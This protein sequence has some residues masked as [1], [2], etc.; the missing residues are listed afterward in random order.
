MNQICS[1][2]SDE[3][4]D[5]ETSSSDSSVFLIRSVH[6]VSQ[7]EELG[8]TILLS[9]EVHGRTLEKLLDTGSPYSIMPKYRMKSVLHVEKRNLPNDKNIVDINRNPI[10]MASRFQVTAN[11]K[12]ITE[13]TTQWEADDIKIPIL[14]M[15]NFKRL[16]LS[17]EGNRK[18]EPTKKSVS[19]T[20][21]AAVPRRDLRED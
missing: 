12:R 1:K 8:S 7:V 9:L 16:K 6:K 21:T 3:G 5:Q 10:K 13:K 2:N 11:F 14:G 20:L 19:W 17:V 15:D 4:E 18:R